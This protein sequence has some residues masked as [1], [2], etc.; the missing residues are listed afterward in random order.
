MKKLFYVTLILLITPLFLS[1][2]PNRMRPQNNMMG[3]MHER[4]FG[5][6]NE[7]RIMDEL[8]LSDKQME[9]IYKI[10]TNVEKEMV[11]IG[12]E[13]KKAE[14]DLK[15]ASFADEL[16]EAKI[17]SLIKKVNELRGKI[18]EKIALAKLEGWKVLTPE[19]RKTV[20]QYVIYGRMK[21]RRQ[22]EKRK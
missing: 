1:A 13:L 22:Y 9:E 4:G 17:K 8:N 7:K 10:R 3:P 12:A 2:K 16:D 19:Q 18:F 20:K 6:L 5:W 14:I 21:D 15:E 11:D